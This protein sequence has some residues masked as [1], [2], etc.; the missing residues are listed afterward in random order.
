MIQNATDPMVFSSSDRNI[1]SAFYVDD[2][3]IT[4]ESQYEDDIKKLIKILA[5]NGLEGKL[6]SNPPKYIGTQ[7]EYLTPHDIL[8]HQE[9]HVVKMLSKTG[10]INAKSLATPMEER[11][12]AL[13][14][15]WGTRGDCYPKFQHLVYNP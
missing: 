5:E 9:D 2:G 4:G 1:Q 11:P 8:C 10:L 14:Y 3:L 6:I 13:L 15:A 7:L 12:I